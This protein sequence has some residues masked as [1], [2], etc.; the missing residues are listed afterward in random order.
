MRYGEQ[1]ARPVAG[2][3]GLWIETVQGQRLKRIGAVRYH[4]ALGI[5]YCDGSSWPE[6]IVRGVLA[7]S[8]AQ[9]EEAPRDMA[10]EMA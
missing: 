3:G 9:R 5:Y 6:E 7:A 8:P 2:A 1:E 4:A 10:K